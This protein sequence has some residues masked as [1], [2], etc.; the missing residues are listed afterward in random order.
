MELCPECRQYYK[1]LQYPTCIQCLSDD[2]RKAVLESIKFGN[3]WR[4][5]H[6]TFG[7]D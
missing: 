2:K 4:E 3:E 7:I 1:G 6:R 5:I